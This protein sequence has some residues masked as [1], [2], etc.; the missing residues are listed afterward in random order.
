MDE[1][2]TL[3][4]TVTVAVGEVEEAKSALM[5]ALEGDFLAVYETSERLPTA[6]EAEQYKTL[7]RIFEHFSLKRA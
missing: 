7:L 3:V 2:T 1:L 4:V 6:E 5:E